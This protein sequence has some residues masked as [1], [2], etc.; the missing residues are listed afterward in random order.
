MR[1]SSPMAVLLSLLALAGSAVGYSFVFDSVSAPTATSDCSCQGIGGVARAYSSWQS[2][3]YGTAGAYAEGGYGAAWA[4]DTTLQQYELCSIATVNGA[5]DQVVH[6]YK[7]VVG[8]L[9]NNDVLVSWVTTKDASGAAQRY[10]TSDPEWW[11]R[12]FVNVTDD[13]PRVEAK[14]SGGDWQ[15]VPLDV[16]ERDLDVR[17]AVVYTASAEAPG[18]NDQV[19]PLDN[20]SVNGVFHGKATVAGPTN[21]THVRASVTLHVTVLGSGDNVQVSDWEVGVLGQFW[22][23][24]E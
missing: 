6:Q 9:D 12:P 1:S 23:S 10:N 2:G 5:Q 24:M 15:D 14:V 4:M 16:D 22:T 3:Q 7:R 11:W 17:T 13:R 19:T 21:K 20:Q 18:P 8:S